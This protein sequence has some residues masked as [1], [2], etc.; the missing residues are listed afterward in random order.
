M[1][2]PFQFKHAFITGFDGESW[3]TQEAEGDSIHLFQNLL[4]TYGILIL[5][6]GT[7]QCTKQSLLSCALRSVGDGLYVNP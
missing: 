3:G 2:I 5:Y 6:T 1:D 4:S 7:Q